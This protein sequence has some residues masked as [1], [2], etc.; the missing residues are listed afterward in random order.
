MLHR[1]ILKPMQKRMEP[2][3]VTTKNG[4]IWIEQEVMG[5]DDSG[6]VIDPSQVPTLIEWLRE[7]AKELQ[8]EP[9]QTKG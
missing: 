2:V 1:T 9:S 3:S 8:I 6:I 4:Q 5:S 7:A